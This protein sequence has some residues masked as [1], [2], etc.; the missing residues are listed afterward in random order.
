[1]IDCVD[2]KDGCCAGGA[3]AGRISGSVGGSV[4]CRVGGSDAGWIAE[5]V[6]SPLDDRAAARMS[7]SSEDCSEGTQFETKE[8]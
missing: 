7:N 8:G 3:G 1:M 2:K 6:G 4:D 5:R